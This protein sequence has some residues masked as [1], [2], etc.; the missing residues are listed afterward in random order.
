MLRSHDHL[1]GAHFISATLLLLAH[2]LEFIKADFN[3]DITN[4]QHSHDAASM[5]PSNC[6][7]MPWKPPIGV[8]G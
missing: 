6:T 3:N 7:A 4:L 2:F 5:P 1:N 8:C